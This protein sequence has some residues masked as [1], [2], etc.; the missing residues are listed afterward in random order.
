[1]SFTVFRRSASVLFAASC[2]FALFVICSSNNVARAQAGAN[3]PTAPANNT[4]PAQRAVPVATLIARLNLTPEQRTQIVAIRQQSEAEAAV[5]TQ[6]L[7][8]A[9][10]ALDAAI[11]ADEVDE[12][13]VQERASELAKVQGEL[14]YLRANTEFKLRRVLTPDQLGILRDNRA[15]E[16]IRRR[17]EQRQ[18]NQQNPPANN[19]QRVPDA[20][21]NRMQ[22]QNNSLDVD[23]KPAQ[24]FNLRERRQNGLQIRQPR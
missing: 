2:L 20:P 8:R 9:R 15:R 22:Q 18:R 16:I 1:M 21:N 11:Y 12:A 24:P 23:A 3:E 6:R 19:S 10:R 17:L 13:V 5:I 14:A 4:G 7:R